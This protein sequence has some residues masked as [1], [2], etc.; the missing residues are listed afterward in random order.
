MSININDKLE[1]ANNLQKRIEELEYFLYSVAKFDGNNNISHR[2]CK[3]YITKTVKTEISIFRDRFSIG[4]HTLTVEVPDEIRDNL[5]EPCEKLLQDLK[6]ELETI[7][8]Y[9]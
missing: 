6:A 9:E 5:I 1:H 8:N 4:E 7:I 3:C 2:K